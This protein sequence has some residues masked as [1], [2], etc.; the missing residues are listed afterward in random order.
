MSGL[1][2][3]NEMQEARNEIGLRKT[4]EAFLHDNN[5]IR[6][7]LIADINKAITKKGRDYITYTVD[8]KIGKTHN[9]I[10]LAIEHGYTLIVHDSVW[11][12]H[13]E[14][15]AK[16]DGKAIR[17]MSIN[18]MKN[19]MDGMKCDVL[20]KDELVDIVDLRDMLEYNG[21]GYVSVV[22]IN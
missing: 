5:R 6:E 16:R 1:Y 13:I 9:L 12:R 17:V 2:I 22:G 3:S 15:E 21:M 10:E 20:L 11:A 7:I 19:R 4:K 18:S 14:R 8:R